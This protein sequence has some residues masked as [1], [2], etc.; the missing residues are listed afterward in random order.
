MPRPRRCRIICQRPEPFCFSSS[1]KAGFPIALLLEEYEALRLIDYLKA[2]HQAASEQMG[3]SRTTMTEI[4]ERARFKVSRAL[5]EQRP[6]VLEEGPGIRLC[7]EDPGCPCKTYERCALG[8]KGDGTM[9]IAVTYEDGKVFGH[10]GHT[11]AF[12]VY[13]VASGKIS[14]TS[15]LESGDTGHSALADLLAEEKVDSLIC[16]GLGMG[17]KTALEQ[18]GITVYPGVEGDADEAAKALLEGRLS[19]DPGASCH[20]HDQEH[21]CSHHCHD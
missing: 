6:L 16:G 21:S 12:K 2:T 19:Y 17:A 9:K 15:M 11:K 18:L 7:Q 8:A 4:Y 3:I 14:S 20:H 10:F 13:E 1:G 5:V